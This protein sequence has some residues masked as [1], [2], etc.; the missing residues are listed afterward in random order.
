[1]D[2]ASDIGFP[3]VAI[4]ERATKQA[5]PAP[6]RKEW[7]EVGGSCGRL[8]NW[9]QGRSQM[10]KWGGKNRE[11]EAKDMTKAVWGYPPSSS[12]SEKQGLLQDKNDTEYP[13]RHMSM[14]F[15]G[16]GETECFPFHGEGKTYAGRKCTITHVGR[17]PRRFPG[18]CPSHSKGSCQVTP[19]CSKVY[20]FQIWEVP[21]INTAQCVWASCSS[22]WLS[23]WVNNFSPQWN[24]ELKIF[25]ALVA[26]W[27]N[28]EGLTPEFP[29]LVLT[30]KRMTN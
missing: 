15:Q 14:H 16:N 9:S 18:Q 19:G 28:C 6:G 10:W 3:M 13:T 11:G 17:D 8:Q 23:S 24:T 4:S 21:W 25:Q 20:S 30:H 27:H 1:M 29:G 12:A 26:T 5:K 7:T 2:F 22:A